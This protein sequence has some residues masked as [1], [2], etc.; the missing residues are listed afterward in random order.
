[1]DIDFRKRCAVTVY[2][3]NYDVIVYGLETMDVTTAFLGADREA[4]ARDI[5]APYAALSVG[6]RRPGSAVARTQHYFN[7]R[8]MTREETQALHA[9]QVGGDEARL[10]AHYGVGGANGA[11]QAATAEGCAGGGDRGTK[12]DFKEE[13]CPGHVASADNPKVCDRC[14][15]HID[16]LRPMEDET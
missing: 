8:I 3:L 11:A 14:G 4:L 15:V 2:G 9:I 5:D 6:G 12:R 13:D 1:M 10:R 16:S 7:K